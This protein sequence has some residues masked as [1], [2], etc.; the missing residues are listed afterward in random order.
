MNK[1]FTIISIILAITFIC[2]FVKFVVIPIN[3]NNTYLNGDHISLNSSTIQIGTLP[4][5][6]GIIYEF[7]NDS[8]KYIIVD[9][10][11]GVAITKK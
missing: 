10:F 8:V 9:T 6:G 7:T 2:L 3:N 11:N 1:I 4:N 5:R